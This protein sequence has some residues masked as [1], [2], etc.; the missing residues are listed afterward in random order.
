[1]AVSRE[2]WRGSRASG[3]GCRSPSSFAFSDEVPKGS[4]IST[5]PAA[6]EV[7]DDY[8]QSWASVSDRGAA[9]RVCAEAALAGFAQR[10]HRVQVRVNFASEFGC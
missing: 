9:G 3:S 6:D 5:T 1:M 2:I 10:E 4:V 7:R 8:L